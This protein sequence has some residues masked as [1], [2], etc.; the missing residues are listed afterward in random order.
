MP[1]MSI[2]HRQI[3]Y[4]EKLADIPVLHVAQIAATLMNRVKDAE[5]AMREAYSLLE[6]AHYCKDSLRNER[7]YAAGIASFK[8]S[9]KSFEDLKT[10][11]ATMPEYEFQLDADGSELPV[12]FDVGLAKLIPKPGVKASQTACERKTHFKNYLAA[13]YRDA[14]AEQ[15]DQELRIEVGARTAEMQKDGISPRIF[16]RALEQFNDWWECHKKE[17]LSLAG[18]AGAAAK[19]VKPKAAESKDKPKRKRKARPPVEKLREI[20]RQHPEVLREIVEQLTN[21]A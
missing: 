20:G 2:E 9:V 10:D 18:K 19:K 12:P 7:S 8:D 16:R 5:E 3:G 21:S 13:I 17:Q 14:R 1:A 6:I 4:A 15:D 11:I